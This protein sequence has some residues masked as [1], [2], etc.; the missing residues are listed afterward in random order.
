MCL[1]G[2]AG[3]APVEY[4]WMRLKNARKTSFN[5]DTCWLCF[6]SFDDAAH[7]KKEVVCNKTAVLHSISYKRLKP[8]SDIK[9]ALSSCK[10]NA[11]ESVIRVH[12]PRR[13]IANNPMRYICNERWMLLA[14]ILP[15]VAPGKHKSYTEEGAISLR[16]E[17]A[18]I[19]FCNE[20]E[21]KTRKPTN[22]CGIYGWR[23]LSQRL[24]SF[25]AAVGPFRF[26]VGP[27]GCSIFGLQY[28]QRWK[29][30]GRGEGSI[31]NVIWLAVNLSGE[32]FA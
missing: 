25:W 5:L 14:K 30:K 28:F 4:S 2:R 21:K 20:S 22:R 19:W 17:S 32:C 27:T 15:I 24:L 3:V 13:C 16:V 26:W 7:A 12:G 8:W 18:E 9:G 1:E 29:E 31:E 11:P 6:I 23:R 10:V